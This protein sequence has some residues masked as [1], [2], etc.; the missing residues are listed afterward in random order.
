M[1][2]LMAVMI[3]FSLI[4]GLGL[5]A[6]PSESSA[7]MYIDYQKKKKAPAKKLITTNTRALSKWDT[8]NAIGANEASRKLVAKAY[9]RAL[10][11]FAQFVPDDVFVKNREQMV[12]A[13]KKSKGKGIYITTKIYE[14]PKAWRG[15]SFTVKFSPRY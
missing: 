11:P 10:G 3:S 7:N 9:D 8:L 4:M 6:A 12:S 1:K 2:R 14:D 15:Y 5:F 13:F